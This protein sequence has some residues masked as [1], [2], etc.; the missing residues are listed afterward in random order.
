MGGAIRLSSRAGEGFSARIDVPIE[1][2]LVTVLWVIAG[3]DEF[4]LPAAN[5]RRVR[6]QRRR[7][8]PPALPH[9]LACLDGRESAEP[10]YVVDLELQGDDDSARRRSRSASTRSGAPRSSSCGRSVR[11]SP[12]SVRSRAPSCAATD[13]CASRIDAWA[14]APRARAFT[15]S[16]PRSSG[17]LAPGPVAR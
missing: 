8:T 11:S 12:G 3:T 1:S 6:L 5:A 16:P 7:R 13:R 2:G 10:R 4:A 15:A 9:L 14:I 17:H